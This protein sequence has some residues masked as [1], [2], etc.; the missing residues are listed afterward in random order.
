MYD[1]NTENLIK[2]AR[3]GYKEAEMPEVQYIEYGGEDGEEKIVTT[4]RPKSDDKDGWGKVNNKSENA[5]E[6]SPIP[7]LDGDI[8][9]SIKTAWA[10]GD[11]P[12]CD[13]IKQ[14]ENIRGDSGEQIKSVNKNIEDQMEAHTKETKQIDIPNLTIPA[15]RILLM[16]IESVECSINEKTESMANNAKAKGYY[17]EINEYA[18]RMNSCVAGAEYPNKWVTAIDEA[19]TYYMKTKNEN[20]IKSVEELHA[21][22]L[23]WKADLRNFVLDDFMASGPRTTNIPEQYKEKME[24]DEV[25]PAAQ[26]ASEPPQGF[27]GQGDQA[28]QPQTAFQ[29]QAGQASEPQNADAGQAS[30]AFESQTPAGDWVSTGYIVDGDRRRT[31]K[32][33]HKQGF[34]LRILLENLSSK[35]EGGVRFF[36]M[37]PYHDYATEEQKEEYL[38]QGKSFIPSFAALARGLLG[39]EVSKETTDST[40]TRSLTKQLGS[41][42]LSSFSVTSIAQYNHETRPIRL[43]EGHI[44]DSKLFS[45]QRWFTFTALKSAWGKS[46]ERRFEKLMKN[47]VFEDGYE[48]VTQ[49]NNGPLE[50][51]DGVYT[52]EEGDGFLVPDP[53]S[54]GKGNNAFEPASAKSIPQST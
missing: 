50:R 46:W 35:A 1:L 49:E 3:G 12:M 51:N 11:G 33:I 2:W 45:Q 10:E 13:V 28:S 17:G 29:G 38:K 22:P 48:D 34:F 15:G 30:K 16:I 39:N 8:A 14:P 53:S 42:P 41:S 47:Y 37:L 43:I 5:P 18:K 4:Q 7:E 19:Y 25:M 24:V 44:P 52:D 6:Q 20:G 27:D 23:F 36:D 21:S 9:A 26:S 54:S 40:L 31:V 32:G